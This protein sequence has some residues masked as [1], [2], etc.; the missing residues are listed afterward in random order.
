VFV[1]ICT[2]KKKKEAKCVSIFHQKYKKNLADLVQPLLL[3]ENWIGNKRNGI[4]DSEDVGYKSN[5]FK[6]TEQ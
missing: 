2:N 4:I 6:V 5:K 1:L 3:N